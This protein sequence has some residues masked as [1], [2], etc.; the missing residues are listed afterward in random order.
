MINQDLLHYYSSPGHYINL[1]NFSKKYDFDLKNTNLKKFLIYLIDNSYYTKDNFISICIYQYLE[2]Y[3]LKIT[4]RNNSKMLNL[5]YKKFI[6]KIFN[7]HKYNLDK[8]SFFIE[9]RSKI[10]YG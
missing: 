9:V 10:F 5:L 1:I 6:Q 4:N 3:L 8:E 2:F 7:M